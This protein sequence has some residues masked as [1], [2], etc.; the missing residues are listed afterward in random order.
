M[1]WEDDYILGI[2]G[3]ILLGSHSVFV[4]VKTVSYICANRRVFED[5]IIS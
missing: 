1:F 4:Y 5:N 3:C 2:L